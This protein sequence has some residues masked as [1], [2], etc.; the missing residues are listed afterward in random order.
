VLP[1][2]MYHLQAPTFS[3]DVKQFIVEF[4]EV[5][6]ICRWSAQV[7]LI[8][9]HLCLMEAGK[10]YDIGQEVSKIFDALRARFGLIA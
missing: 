5:A 7:T 3:E 10:P 4:S 8:Q 2:D 1:I 9:L 6:T